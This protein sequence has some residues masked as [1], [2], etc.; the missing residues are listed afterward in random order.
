MNYS[1]L[2]NQKNNELALLYKIFQIKDDIAKI[3]SE[4]G[5]K[6]KKNVERDCQQRT[7]Y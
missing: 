5:D 7:R 2:V 4:S 3:D 1:K 6:Q